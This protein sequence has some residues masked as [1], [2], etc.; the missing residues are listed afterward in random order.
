MSGVLGESF[1]LEFWFLLVQVSI[2]RNTEI[3][4]G[5]GFRVYGLGLLGFR[6]RV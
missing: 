3:V 6:F 2:T 1:E 5:S 4:Q